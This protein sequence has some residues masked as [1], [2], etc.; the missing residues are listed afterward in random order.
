MEGHT[1]PYRYWASRRH[2]SSPPLHPPSRLL[3][4]SRSTEPNREKSE[5]REKPVETRL[6][7]WSVG[8]QNPRHFPEA[9]RLNPLLEVPERTT[10]GATT[11]T[12]TPQPSIHH[13]GKRHMSLP[14]LPASRAPRQVSGMRY[15]SCVCVCLSC[16]F[17]FPELPRYTMHWL[18][19]RRLNS[20]RP[21]H[22][23]LVSIRLPAIS[24]PTTRGCY[25]QLLPLGA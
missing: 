24:E 13:Q 7:E 18:D 22:S 3:C 12:P 23:S 1:E 15:P 9:T 6:F 2:H 14:T 21:S 16:P 11:P 5:R 17:A 20:R 25:S 19:G 8:H 4:T 10:A